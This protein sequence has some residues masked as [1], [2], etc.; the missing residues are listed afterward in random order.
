MVGIDLPA[1]LRFAPRGVIAISVLF[2][3][4]TA[5]LAQQTTGTPGSPT[6]GV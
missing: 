5:G 2:A 6:R 4:G 3:L 1:T